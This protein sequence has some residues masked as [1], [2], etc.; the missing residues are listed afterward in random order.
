[1]AHIVPLGKIN[2]FLADNKLDI[3]DHADVQDLEETAAS[4]VIGKLSK[5][6]NVDGWDTLP[7]PDE[8]PPLVVSTIGMLTAGYAYNRLFAEDTATGVTYGDKLKQEAMALI[9]QIL[10]EEI[11]LTGVDLTDLDTTP[12]NPGYLEVDPVFSMGTSF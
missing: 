3:E 4:W 10:N 2:Q 7:D 11:P 8:R 6:Y 12:G 5:R 1:M 9:E